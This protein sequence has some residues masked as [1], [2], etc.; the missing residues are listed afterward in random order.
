VG[1]AQRGSHHRR[2]PPSADWTGAAEAASG[3]GDSCGHG[4]RA[5]IPA[6]STD[7]RASA[8][9]ALKLVIRA[10]NVAKSNGSVVYGK[11]GRRGIRRPTCP[12][13]LRAPFLWKCARSGHGKPSRREGKRIARPHYAILERAELDGVCYNHFNYSASG[14]G[15]RRRSIGDCNY[16]CGLVLCPVSRCP[17]VCVAW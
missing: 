3:Y 2:E 11:R 17:V 5:G 9:E 16:F 14:R 8:G 12:Y 4:E 15:G 1:R 6:R 10:N 13:V 7:E